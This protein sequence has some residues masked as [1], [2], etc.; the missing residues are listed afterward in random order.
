MALAGAGGAGEEGGLKGC[1]RE[2]VC[3]GAG[4]GLRLGRAEGYEGELKE[5]RL[6]KY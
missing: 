1:Y 2:A 5:I 4:L 3:V 6:V